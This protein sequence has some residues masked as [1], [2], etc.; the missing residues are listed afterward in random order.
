MLKARKIFEHFYGFE[1]FF[2][3]WQRLCLDSVYFLLNCSEDYLIIY[4]CSLILDTE[5]AHL[6][7]IQIATMDHLR[8]CSISNPN[9]QKF[10]FHL[11]YRITYHFSLSLN[12]VLLVF[13][14]SPLHT[15]GTN[16]R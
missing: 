2:P 16:V 5:H 14:I 1:S 11:L 4:F 8:Y 15:R 3:F 12:N 7:G 6:D 13:D 10:I 9:I